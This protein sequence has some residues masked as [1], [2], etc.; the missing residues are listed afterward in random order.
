M[1]ALRLNVAGLLKESAGAA[2][3]YRVHVEPE[4]L[5]GMLEDARPVAPL[6]GEVRLMRTP[7]SIFVRGQMGTRVAGECSRCLTEVETPVQ[8][9]VEAEYFPEVDIATGHALPTPEDDLAFTIDA[10]HELDLSEVARQSL[11][12][13]Q[14]MQ[15]LC[16]ETC[17][18]LCP[19]CGA[20]LNQG[21]CSCEPDVDERLTPLRDLLQRSGRP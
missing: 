9:D 8:F 18:G 17:A 3:D 6:D 16:S 1:S 21:A 12:L 11:L 5:V 14:P 2:R 4:D 19:T 15:L 20:D 7:R 10:N 13:A